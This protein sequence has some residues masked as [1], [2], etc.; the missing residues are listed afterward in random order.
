MY[1]FLTQQTKLQ[2]NKV[3]TN[4]NM[5][6][7][8]FADFHGSAS[9]LNTALSIIKT[10]HPDKTVICGDLFGGW[11]SSR[12]I[13]DSLQGLD[14]VL[15]L[16]RGN[17]DHSFD[18]SLLPYGM[19]DNATMYHFGRTLFFTHGDR[20]N[21]YNI[22]PI[23]TQG[24]VLIHGHTHVN[25]T[26]VVNGLQVLNIGSMARPRDNQPAYLQLDDDGATYFSPDGKRLLFRPWLVKE[27]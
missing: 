16:V 25:R 2:H 1:F 4:V 11:S 21:G 13:A 20:Y 5:K 14:T 10:Q 22:P 27:Q 3:R 8:V 26:Y 23:L 9:A 6:I 19:E 18:V 24:D 7:L 15:Y 17:N 12:Q